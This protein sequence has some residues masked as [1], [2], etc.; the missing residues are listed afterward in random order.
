MV[1]WSFDISSI[2]DRVISANNISLEGVDYATAVQ[3]L[4]DSGQNVNLVVKRRVVLPPTI[5]ASAA[6]SPAKEAVS[7]SKSLSVSLNRS[8]KK[9]DFG[10]VLG[11]KI[12]IKEVVSRTVADKSG[13]LKQGD[14][15]TKINGTD[16]DGL[17]LKDA[18][19]LVESSKDRLDLI[20]RR[21]PETFKP[22]IL[23][24]NKNIYQ[25]PQPQQQQ[26]QQQQQ[27]APN[28]Q[29]T[30]PRPPLPSSDP[31]MLRTFFFCQTSFTE[32]MPI[33]APFLITSRHTTN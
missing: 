21:I 13:S 4:R 10:I 32:K 26:Q 25:E 19:K 23:D 18:K 29:G 1:N 11:C 14:L 15:V 8:R 3:V 20:I 7:E 17:T 30:P 22:Q 12:F 27:Q 24:T 2:N 28:G 31:G 5:P 16:L 9:E 6:I 33:F